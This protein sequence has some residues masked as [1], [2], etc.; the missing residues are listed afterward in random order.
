MTKDFFHH[1]GYFYEPEPGWF[2]QSVSVVTTWIYTVWNA[3]FWIGIQLVIVTITIMLLYLLWHTIKKQISTQPTSSA[4]QT[5]PAYNTQM[6]INVWLSDINE[7]FE[8]SKINKEKEKQEHILKHLDKSSRKII[9]RLIDDKKITT[10]SE[11]EATLKSY[12][13]NNNLTTQD[14]VYQF[15]NKDN[16]HKKH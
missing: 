1:F 14:D 10:F 12:F 5:P 11:S 13:G 15:I 3:R 16:N 2:E 4:Q 7:F 6:S 8:T 9:Q